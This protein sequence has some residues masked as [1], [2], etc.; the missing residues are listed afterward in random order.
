MAEEGT[1]HFWILMA[2]DGGG[3]LAEMYSHRFTKLVD[4]D[5]RYYY[6]ADEDNIYS[7]PDFMSLTIE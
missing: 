4:T 1:F 5:A 2:N 6:K 3:G 7:G